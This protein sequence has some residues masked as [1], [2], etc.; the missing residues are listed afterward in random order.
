MTSLGE[1]NRMTSSKNASTAF[2]FRGRWVECHQKNFFFYRIDLPASLAS[3]SSK[4][5]PGRKISTDRPTGAF[6]QQLRWST[7]DFFT[8]SDTKAAV[9]AQL[10]FRFKVAS[11][12]VKLLFSVTWLQILWIFGVQIDQITE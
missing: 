6:S 1:K 2:Q 10:D 12:Q 9:E 7:N 4:S 11:A 3:F 5:G 8:L